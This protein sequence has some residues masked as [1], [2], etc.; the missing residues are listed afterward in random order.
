MKVALLFLLSTISVLATS[1]SCIDFQENMDSKIRSLVSESYTNIKFTEL[2]IL[3][4]D[5]NSLV[6]CDYVDF[7][8]PSK[9][10]IKNDLIVKLNLFKDDQFIKRVTKIFRFTGKAEVLRTNKIVENGD[11]AT[12]AL[13]I[14]QV[15]LSKVSYRT[16]SNIDTSKM[17]FRNYITKNQIVEDWM[18]D[19]IPDVKK[20]ERIKAIVKKDNIT[21]TLDGR[22]L[23]NGNIG[24]SIKIQL[25]DKIKIGK[26]YDKKTAIINNI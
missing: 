21:L 20:G 26:I 17:Q 19:S 24:N 5:S 15:D 7:E 4:I 14:D 8:M 23:E 2:N 22:V 13:Y 10:N 16:I 25:N 18:I 11:F 9:L 3:N 6:N 1:M 12:N